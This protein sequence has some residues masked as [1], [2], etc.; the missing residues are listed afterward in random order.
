MK[1]LNSF[2]ASAICILNNNTK[3]L[4][5]SKNIDDFFD[6]TETVKSFI[7]R[8]FLFMKPSA[9]KYSPY[10]TLSKFELTQFLAFGLPSVRHV[11]YVCINGI[12]IEPVN[13]KL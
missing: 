4:F 9:L 11:Q 1:Q 10:K 8:T 7:F 13:S 6:D 3:I 12:G 2:Q 5:M